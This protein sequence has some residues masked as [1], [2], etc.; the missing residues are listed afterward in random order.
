M[1]CQYEFPGRGED[2]DSEDENAYH[3]AAHITIANICGLEL[4]PEG[5]LILEST[6]ASKNLEG[7]ACYHEGDLDDI[8]N[9]KNVLV[10]LMAGMRAQDLK[11]PETAPHYSLS[12]AD[13]VFKILCRFD[14][15]PSREAVNEECR[16][17]LGVHWHVIE[18]TALALSQQPWQD[19][20][21]E[22]RKSGWG[23]KKQLNRES[24]LAIVREPAKS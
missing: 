16:R 3:E 18:A 13:K 24:I 17:L 19:A 14:F 10:A 12:D 5:I 8:D 20:T 6:S 11:F 22:E 9:R 15:K 7:N 2:W 23:R 4:L 21:E 1:R